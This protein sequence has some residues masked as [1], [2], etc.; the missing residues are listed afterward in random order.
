[1]AAKKSSKKTEEPEASAKLFY[2]FYNQ[3]RWDNWL[4]TLA[5]ADFS[6]DD[7]SDEM[8]E[9]Y[10]ILDGFSDDITLATIK[11]I[12][13]FQNKRISLEDARTKLRG[14]EEIVMGEVQNVDVAEIIGSMQVSMLVLFAAGQKYLEE[15]YP[16]A[17]EVKNLVK[18][19]RKAFDKDP[20][21]ALDM[22]SSIGA[23]VING[24]S[25]CGKY[26]KDTDEPTLFD[27]WLVE[28]ERIADALKSLKNF[29][30]EAGEAQ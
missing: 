28:V 5:E 9:G 17:E 10:R 4:N 23:A 19:G 18:D 6:G 8:P 11:I 21:K 3:E 16:P 26:V 25:C 13:L 15:S 7:D 24:A 20:E 29:D 14:V 2:I 12:K 1:M 27:E 22:A 30:E